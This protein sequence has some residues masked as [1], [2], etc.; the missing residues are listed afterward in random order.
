MLAKLRIKL[1]K[2][3]AEKDNFGDVTF[4][5]T[6]IDSKATLALDKA[7]NLLSEIDKN[8]PKNDNYSDDGGIDFVDTINS[9]N[10]IALKKRIDYYLVIDETYFKNL[11]YLEKNLIR[12]CVTDYALSESLMQSNEISGEARS[13]FRFIVLMFEFCMSQ[14]NISASEMK[15]ES[16]LGAARAWGRNDG[17]ADWFSGI[18]REVGVKIEFVEEQGLGR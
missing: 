5:L 17:G 14:N 1:D 9:N 13:I 7:L 6:N 3:S 18:A 15:I 8:K 12:C 16:A 2:L 4:L 10:R 11:G